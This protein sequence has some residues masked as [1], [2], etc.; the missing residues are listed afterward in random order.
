MTSNFDIDIHSVWRIHILAPLQSLHCL[1][2]SVDRRFKN[3][4][5]SIPK[6]ERVYK[7][8]L[9]QTLRILMILSIDDKIRDLCDGGP[10]QKV[11]DHLHIPIHCLHCLISADHPISPSPSGTDGENTLLCSILSILILK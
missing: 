6:V 3:L 8:L 10:H 4:L 1:D 5:T 2:V 11:A 9:C 7:C